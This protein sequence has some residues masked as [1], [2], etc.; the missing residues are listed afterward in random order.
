MPNDFG[1]G[2]RVDQ[3]RHER[4][5]LSR[6]RVRRQRRIVAALL[7]VAVLVLGVLVAA[8]FVPAPGS[9]PPEAGAGADRAA[10]PRPP[11]LPR[12]GRELLPRYRVVAFYG[13]PQ[14][15]ELGVLGIGELDDVGRKLLR[16]A[17]A[18]RR[19]E[20]PIMPAFELLATIASAEAGDDG[21]YRY[22]QKAAVI[23][24]HLRAA[25]KAKALLILDIQPGREDF[26]TEARHY[27]RWLEQP[28]VSLALDPE[29][30]ME[31]GQVPGQ[32]IG[33]TDAR[34]VNR[35]SAYLDG[36]VR[37]RNL[38]QKMLLIHQFTEDMI[39]DRDDL[40]PRPGV[41]LVRNVD[42]FGNPE[43]KKQKYRE[44]TRGPRRT[45]MG[46]KLFYREDTN[47]MAPRDVLR[48]RPRPDVVVYE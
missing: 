19:G 46:Y 1:P 38:P 22:R 39:E 34:T 45:R 25:R 44:F 5:E 18:Y 26:M 30:S 10:A 33:S 23:D 42:G 43:I 6:R 21:K 28:D 17:R 40:K 48:L 35:V 2:S 24:R 36:I 8:A 12:G 41:V 37:R 11:E 4:R 14:A 16:Q 3:G 15:D 9:G 47:L 27:R 32:Q 7:G 31:E 29:W 20:R 13:A